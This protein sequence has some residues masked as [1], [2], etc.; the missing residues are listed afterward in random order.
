MSR[1]FQGQAGQQVP[2]MTDEYVNSVSDRYIELYEIITGEKFIRA[3]VKDVLG[4]VERNV[5]GF[6][7]KNL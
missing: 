6:L 4:R 5:N 1:G 7:E 2:E 3:D